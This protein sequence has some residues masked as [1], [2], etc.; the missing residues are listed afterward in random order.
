MNI[1][2]IKQRIASSLLFLLTGCVSLMAQ[3]AF[4]VRGNVADANRE[5]VIGASVKVKGTQTGTVTDADGNY[6]ITTRKNATLVFSSLGFVSQEIPVNR[7]GIINVTLQEQ[8]GKL[9]EVVVVGYGTQKKISVTGAV[10]NISTKDLVRQSTPSLSNT[11]GGQ[12]PG[13]ITRQATGEPGYDQASVYIRGFGTWTNRAPLV[14]VDGI[15]RD[16]NTINTEEVESISVL[17]DASATAVYGV[18]G[19][20][21]VILIT[22]KKGTMGK[23]KITLRTEFATLHGLRYPEYIDAAEYAS[24]TN[25]ARRNVGMQNMA[26]TD[27]EIELY[28]DGSSPYLYPN[29]NWVDK[30]LKKN[31]TQSITN[32]N[33]SGGNEIVRYF[34]NVGYTTQSG[35]YHDNGDN[36][37]STNARI[38]RYNYRSRVDVNLTK[39]LSVELGVGG[40]IQNRNFPG[41]SQY[42]IFTAVRMTPALSFPYKNPDGTPGANPTYVGNNPWAMV[43]QSG[44]ETQN[45]NTLQGTFSVH[46]DLSSLVTKGLSVNG[47][48]AYDHYYSNNKVYGKDYEV[49]Q[50]VGDDAEG[51]AIYNIL[52]NENIKNVTLNESANRAIYYE[53]SANYDRSFG[54]HNVAGM[55]LFNRRDYVDLRNTNRV[56]SVPYRRQ[57]IAGRVSYNYKTRYFAEFNFGYNGSEQFPPGKRFGFFPSISLGYAINNE[58]FWNQNWAVSTLKLRGSYGEVGNDISGSDRFLYL[59]T[60]NMD[61]SAGHMGKDGNSYQVGITEGQIGTP[62]V[63]W[64]KSKKLNVGVDLGFFHDALTLNLDYFSEKRSGILLQRGTIPVLA[65]FSGASTP[66]GNLGKAENH[67]F[68]AALEMKKTLKNGL[69]YSLRGNFSFA[70][71]KIIENDEPHPK[72]EYQDARGRRI[73]QTFGLVAIGFFKDQDDINNSPKQMFQSVVRPGDIKYKD[74][75]GDNVVDEYDRVAIGDPRTPEIMFGFGG[76]VAWK[77]FD[78]SLFFTGAAKTSFFLEG[79]TVYP[80][81]SGEGT[82]NVLREV[83]DNRWTPSTAATAKYPIVI[84]G[85]SPN[86]YQTSTMYM[87]NGSYLRLKSAEVGYTFKGA[88]VDRMWMDSIRLFCN[89]QNLAT[90]DYIKIVDPESN[91]G[92]GNYPLQMTI[93]FGVQINF[94]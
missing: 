81:Q 36:A 82:W 40:I 3:E 45:W 31:T 73:D 72:Y 22:T 89:G 15:E 44:Y 86:N 4:K 94:K 52:R 63:T 6:E 61:T 10:S 53:V 19:A 33:I 74:V 37:Y 39:D 8:T 9:D 62:N 93:N 42:D 85:N 41:R 70:R 23:P 87:R 60:M 35:L 13:L 71:N 12:I 51:N 92:V 55:F 47:R 64:E 50:Y 32:L 77:G 78:A 76:T 27:E 43:T 2:L 80:F 69:F 24:L 79:S 29:V 34:V 84:N 91:N 26:Y 18:R 59:T 57:G 25:E 83:Y 90:F 16:M 67:G 30:I 54:P 11:L 21:G 56:G 68:E 88:F 28:R 49:K 38:N 17:K 14:L 5:P 75:N 1:H 66:R 20:N 7:S 46:W 48:F 58:G 65:G